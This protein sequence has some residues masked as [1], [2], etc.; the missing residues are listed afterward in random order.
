MDLKE[1]LRDIMFFLEA[2]KQIEASDAKD[3]IAGGKIVIAEPAKSR[4]T[5]S[6][7]QRKRKD[8]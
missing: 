2:Q 3:E 4:N 5:V 1:Q 6:G 8:R 7:K